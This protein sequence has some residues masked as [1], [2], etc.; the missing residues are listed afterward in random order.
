MLHKRTRARCVL[1]FAASAYRGRSA[2]IKREVSIGTAVRP[3][4]SECGA[5]EELGIANWNR[6]IEID[7]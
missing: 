1:R 4:H 3:S 7:C 2:R 5:R 6:A